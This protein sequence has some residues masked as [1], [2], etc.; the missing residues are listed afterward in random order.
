MR[1]RR[2][3]YS[4]RQ[5]IFVVDYN[6]CSIDRL[7]DWNLEE[8]RRGF[9][10]INIPQY[11]R[12][13]SGRLIY[14][15][16]GEY[17]CQDCGFT[18]LDDWGIIKNYLIE[19][20]AASAVQISYA[21]GVELSVINHYLDNGDIQVADGELYF[22]RCE[23]CGKPIPGGRFCDVCLNELTGGLKGAFSQ[24]KMPAA[25]NDS[26]QGMRRFKGKK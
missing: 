18:M 13:C 22:M 17:I 16:S 19:N 1:I 24:R 11:C 8:K 2:R 26:M 20:G 25:A 12:R 5:I 14:S 15:G 7:R 21:T 10:Q 23:K 3:L 9:E 4:Q 6:K